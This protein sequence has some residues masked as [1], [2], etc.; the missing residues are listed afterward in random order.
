MHLGSNRAIFDSQEEGKKKKSKNNLNFSILEEVEDFENGE[1]EEKRKNHRSMMSTN[2]N[3]RVKVLPK[4]RG[5]RKT[6]K[7]E[8]GK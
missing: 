8:L 1:F 6:Y 3:N 5:F 2:S 7:Y 4:N